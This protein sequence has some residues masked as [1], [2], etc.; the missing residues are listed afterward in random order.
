MKR[1]RQAHLWI[2]L[3]TSIFLL[4]EAVTGLL[5]AEPWLIGQQERG[6]YRE[7]FSPNSSAPE[8]FNNV[9]EGRQVREAVV[10]C[11]HHPR[12]A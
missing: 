10:A 9:Q 7:V 5:L 3:I 8:H 1:I 11:W 12:A 2:G 6:V 4:M